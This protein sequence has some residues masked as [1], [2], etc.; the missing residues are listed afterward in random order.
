[1]PCNQKNPKAQDPNY[2]CNPRTNRWNKKKQ[3]TITKTKQKVMIKSK[4]K[5]SDCNQ[6]NPKAQ[7]PNYECNPYTK[8]WNK[9]KHTRNKIVQKIQDGDIISN[10]LRK[11][12]IHQYPLLKNVPNIQTKP[13]HE[14]LDLIPVLEWKEKCKKMEESCPMDT[15]LSG[16]KWCSLRPKDVFYYQKDGKNYCYGVKEI[17]SIIHLGFTARDTSY[18]VPPLRLQLPRDSYDRSV[19]TKDFFKALKEHIFKY[20]IIPHEPEVCYFLKYY[21]KFY[22]DRAIRSFLTQTDPNK[23]QLSN[24]IQKFLLKYKSIGLNLNTD[25]WFWKRSRPNDMINFIF[26]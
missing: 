26:G 2:E 20:G 25:K 19:F 18:E 14:I 23:V 16:D 4:T 9:K 5:T 13:I 10:V 17:F 6:K 12:L 21:E 24:A 7:D 11:D 8:R 15:D 1:M 3:P 22:M